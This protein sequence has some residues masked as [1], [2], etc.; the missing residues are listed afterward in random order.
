VESESTSVGSVIENQRI[1][2]LPLNGRQAT[3]LIPLTAATISGGV[4]GTA[5][6]PVGQN[7]ATAGGMLS[8][9]TTFWMEPCITT[10]LTPPILHFRFR[11]LC[12]NLKWKPAR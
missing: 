6:F 3:D 8:G 9:V 2:D 1:L 12:R 5:G 11:T 10:R 4:N 7:I